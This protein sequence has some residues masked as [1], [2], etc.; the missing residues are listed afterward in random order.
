M[1]EGLLYNLVKE[2]IPFVLN[3]IL[4]HFLIH[5]GNGNTSACKKWYKNKQMQNLLSWGYTLL[6]P[7]YFFTWWYTFWTSS[8]FQLSVSPTHNSH[9]CIFT[10]G[11]ACFGGTVNIYSLR[12]PCY[13]SRL[14]AVWF[15][16]HEAQPMRHSH[17]ANQ[18]GFHTLL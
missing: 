12:M 1:T 2:G 7:V 14:R 8:M 5:S 13:L 9:I 3:M 4:K 15:N 17:V 16:R 6:T 10:E 11:K 18:I